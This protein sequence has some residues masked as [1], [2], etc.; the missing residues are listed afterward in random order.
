MTLPYDGEDHE[1]TADYTRRVKDGLPTPR[2]EVMLMDG[3]K[4]SSSA[5]TAH[6]ELTYGIVVV[7][8]DLNDDYGRGKDAIT[9]DL[10]NTVPYIM[11]EL[12][13]DITR[14]GN[15][16]DTDVDEF[17]IRF[18]DYSDDVIELNIIIPLTIT[19]HLDESDP[20]TRVG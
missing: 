17:F 14:G 15:A 16:I 6:W 4:S 11:A 13:A 9:N 2:A 8:A 18:L 7:V 20:F 3:R 10:R 5:R 19:V 1:L 12:Q